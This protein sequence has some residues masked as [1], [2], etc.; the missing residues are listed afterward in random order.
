M[1]NNPFD[2]SKDGK[3]G[4]VDG[5]RFH[6]RQSEENKQKIKDYIEE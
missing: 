5:V 6:I 1:F 4:F 2:I 3:N